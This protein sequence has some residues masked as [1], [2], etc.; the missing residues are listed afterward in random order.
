MMNNRYQEH[1]AKYQQKQI[2]CVDYI[3]SDCQL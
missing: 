2:S 1:V 3:E